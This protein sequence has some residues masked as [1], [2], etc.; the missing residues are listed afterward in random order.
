[1]TS[2][3]E[4]RITRAL[5]S[6][7]KPDKVQAAALQKTGQ[8]AYKNGDVKGAIESFTKALAADNEDIGVLDNRAAAYCKLK[9]YSPARSD[10]RA[11]VKLAPKDDRGYLRLA[12]VLC[13]DGNFDKAQV[14]YEYALQKLPANHA[15]RDVV[16]QSLK[17]LQDKLAGGNRRDPFTALPLE[18]ADLI[19][20][21]LSFKQIAAIMRVCQGWRRFLIGL[22]NLWMH[23]DLTGARS[24]VPW[25]SVRDYIHRSRVQVT[26][27]TIANVCNSATPKVLQMLS[28]CPKL[29]HL[30]FQVFCGPRD[31]YPKIQEFRH[32]KTLVCGPDIKI[33]H[34]CVGSILS[35]LTKLEKA[36]FFH[37]WDRITQVP[38]PTP[39]WPTY[40]PNLKSLTLG[41][42]QDSRISLTSTHTFGDV[43]PG[44]TSSV[45]P[46]LEELRLLWNTARSR[47]YEFCPMRGDG[48]ELPILPPLRTLDLRGAVIE[49]R[50]Y[51]LLP[52]TLESL[53]VES[54]GVT[55]DSLHMYDN[56]LRNL[57]TLIF[58]EC[59]WINN[60]SLIIFASRS[61]A[62][63][64][65]LHINFCH[66]ADYAGL[67]RLLLTPGAMERSRGLTELCVACMD[68]LDDY[69][70]KEVSERLPNLSVLD[71]SQTKITGCTIRLFAD[72]RKDGTKVAQLDVLIIR[73]CDAVSRDAIDYGRQM[74]IKI[75]T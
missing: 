43:V 8:N 4:S 21:Y 68:G 67:S 62:P 34:A 57:K 75:I 40:L 71:L 55:D 5:A 73:G 44:L 10:A 63:L 27:A 19:L 38:Q 65:T 22:S 41:C 30:E 33:S 58:N 7:K 46:N 26:N 9:L 32:L 39:T 31:F 20:S 74:G 35:T 37:V 25:T 17:K 72:A 2:R 59:L 14:I 64:E 66:K 6:K 50:F 18:V 45:Y 13:L 51:S 69:A 47:H 42:S 56:K 16:M 60:D 53:R 28:R 1:M 23:V 36:T 48:E 29:E 61:E 15:G 3:P 54:S 70:M 11:M 52:A 12:K 24:R 49:P